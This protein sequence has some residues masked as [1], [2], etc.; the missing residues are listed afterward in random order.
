MGNW[1]NFYGVLLTLYIALPCL[2]VIWV[3]RQDVF[4]HLVT[5]KGTTTRD[6][7]VKWLPGLIVVYI[8]VLLNDFCVQCSVCSVRMRDAGK[9]VSS[10]FCCCCKLHY[11]SVIN[12]KEGKT[13]KSLDIALL[14]AT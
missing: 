12:L 4:E 9:H 7:A 11:L 3:L 14:F 10:C 13:V 2:T 1:K 8:S 5:S 6:S